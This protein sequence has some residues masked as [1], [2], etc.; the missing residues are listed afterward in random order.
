MDE[1]NKKLLKIGNLISWAIMFVF[2]MLATIGIIGVSNTGAIADLYPNLLVPSGFVF[3]IIWNIIFF[4]QLLF[5][6]YSSRDLF[7]ESAKNVDMPY[8]EQVNIFFIIANAMNT[9]WIIVWGY[10]LPIVSIFFMIGLLI[11]LMIIYLRLGIGTDSNERTIKDKI[12]VD[13]TFSWYFA[14]ISIATIA[15]VTAIL[16]YLGYTDGGAFLGTLLPG[17]V[18]GTPFLLINDVAWFCVMTLVGAVLAI[19]VMR[20]RKDLVFGGLVAFALSGIFL[21]RILDFWPLG[22]YAG[23][24][25]DFVI[26]AMIIVGIYLLRQKKVN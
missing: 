23:M 1:K 11:C 14:W 13:F 24:C 7:M 9:A 12:C 6:L 18:A 2:N 20:E 3:P 4:S 22:L 8:L 19:I 26:A 17:A 21:K 15:N 16:V 25:A 10:L 5:A